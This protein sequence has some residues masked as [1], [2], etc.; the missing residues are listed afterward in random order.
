M[1]MRLKVEPGPVDLGRALV[2]GEHGVEARD[3]AAR[4][5][6]A[7]GRVALGLGDRALRGAFGPRDRFVRALRRVVHLLL[8]LLAR[9]VD[10]VERRLHAQRRYHVLELNGDD[11]DAVVVA[12][13]R[14]LDL[15]ARGVR[16]LDTADREHDAA[17]PVTDDP[18]HHGLGQ[19]AQRLR[20]LAH[21]VEVLHRVV[22]PILHD[23]FDLDDV[24]VAREHQRFVGVAARE[25]SA[26][27]IALVGPLGAEAELLL[28]HALRRYDLHAVD[29]ERQLRV[30]AVV[31]DAG[32]TA[33]ALDDRALLGLYRVEGARG[34]PDRGQDADPDQHR[35]P[36]EAGRPGRGR[37]RAVWAPRASRALQQLLDDVTRVAH[38]LVLVPCEGASVQCRSG[39]PRVCRSG[40][41][42]ACGANVTSD[43]AG[44]RAHGTIGLLRSTLERA[45][46]TRRTDA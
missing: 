37:P 38:R 16:D 44:A 19:V 23:P 18:A 42:R 15:V 41:P 22:D 40:R 30:P 10:L 1:V 46:P 32:H 36:R 34:G 5:V 27:A 28:Q 13:H 25:L 29:S 20:R 24:Q 33:E 21:P 39:R 12:G 7:L 2:L 31:G 35:A 14:V 3:V 43:C 8:E 4:A 26:R 6:H 9:L 45:P 11:L 17:D